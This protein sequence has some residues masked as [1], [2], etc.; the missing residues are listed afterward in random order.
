MTFGI[1]QEAFLLMVIDE[2]AWIIGKAATV[3]RLLCYP[4]HNLISKLS[5]I[6]V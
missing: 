2:G 4:A 3:V 1:E 5:I 6:T